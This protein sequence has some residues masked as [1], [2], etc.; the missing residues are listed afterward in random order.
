MHLVTI[1][2]RHLRD[3][4]QLKDSVG[5]N[6]TEDD[7]LRCMRLQPD[8]CVGIVADDKVVATATTMNYGA[9][10]SWIGMVLTLPEYRGRGLARQLM[11]VVIERSKTARVG[12]DA[13]D[14]GKP[15][16]ASLGFVDECAIERWVR[17]PAPAAGESLPAAKIDFGLDRQI[18]GADRSRLLA[19]LG[20][21]ESAGSNGSYAFA[22][23]GSRYHFLG[24]WVAGDLDGARALLGWFL[25][26]HGS[27]T[28][29]VDVFPH[30]EH[31]VSL[32]EE[33]G[34]SRVRR[35]TRMVLAPAVPK[36][37]DARI[38]GIAGFEFG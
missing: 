14:M 5:W 1:E 12:L 29:C 2:P 4:M 33:S 20:R 38:Y 16:Y 10:L 23:P 18:F 3:L 25:A 37:P 17:E 21:Y 7:W 9:E 15:L 30:Q 19:E 26:R 32:I 31:A 36:L 35:L 11:E 24:P 8:G 22:R 6:Q 34:F 13:S 27:K 28:T